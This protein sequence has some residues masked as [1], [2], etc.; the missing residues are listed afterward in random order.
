MGLRKIVYSAQYVNEYN[1]IQIN[2]FK[3]NTGQYNRIVIKIDKWSSRLNPNTHTQLDT[4]NH[5]HT[6]THNHT[7]TGLVAPGD[8]PM[9]G[10]LD[11]A[12]KL[13]LLLLG[14]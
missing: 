8:S 1:S 2:S 4:H 9:S 5:T 7:Q 12:Q 14:T 11:R 6:V 3:V 13:Q 10:G